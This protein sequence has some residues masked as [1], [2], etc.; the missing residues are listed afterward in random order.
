MLCAAAGN[1]SLDALRAMRATPGAGFQLLSQVA[2]LLNP[3]AVGDWVSL[4]AIV[5]FGATCGLA[6]AALAAARRGVAS[7]EAGIVNGGPGG[8]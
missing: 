2:K 8:A 3:A 5:L 4:V 1:A 6:W 7:R